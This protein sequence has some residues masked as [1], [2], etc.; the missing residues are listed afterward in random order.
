MSTT[1]PS[2]L[3]RPQRS[4]Y[5]L[6]IG[7]AATAT[8]R[9]RAA[10]RCRRI[11]QG[12]R[13]TVSLTWHLTEEQFATFAAWWRYDLLQGSLPAIIALPNGVDD[14]AQSVQFLGT[15]SADDMDGRWRVAV[16]AELLAPPR[17]STDDLA[18]LIANGSLILPALSLHTL[19][20]TSIPARILP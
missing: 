4:G 5:V 20:H 6:T 1:Y 19:V 7:A 14:I 11:G 8:Q 2:V 18:G 12:S 13:S 3:P 16:T 15:Y 17:L 10:D 9:E